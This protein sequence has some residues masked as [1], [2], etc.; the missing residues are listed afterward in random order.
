MF[1]TCCRSF[2][3]NNSIPSWILTMAMLEMKNNFIQIYLSIRLDQ[4]QPPRMLVLFFFD[5]IWFSFSFFKS[6]IYEHLHIKMNSHMRPNRN[7][8]RIS[9]TNVFLSTFESHK[10]LWRSKRKLRKDETCWRT[11]ESFMQLVLLLSAHLEINRSNS[12]DDLQR[13]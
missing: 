2:Q 10:I 7:N 12:L 5:S 3:I 4:F 8:I 6:W 1:Y 13:L 11:L 9:G